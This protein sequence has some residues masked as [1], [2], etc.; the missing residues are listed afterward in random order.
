MQRLR[1]I[2]FSN[3][4]IT[5][6]AVLLPRNI[7][8]RLI[9][10]PSRKFRLSAIAW[11][12]REKRQPRGLLIFFLHTLEPK[13]N[14]RQF[15]YKFFKIIFSLIFNRNLEDD[16]TCMMN[17]IASNDNTFRL[18]VWGHVSAIMPWLQER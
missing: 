12:L 14:R 1:E 16:K 11:K 4:V 5:V 2:L 17:C 15:N 6:I 10:V 13:N 9:C 7:A 8:E 3:C 18:N